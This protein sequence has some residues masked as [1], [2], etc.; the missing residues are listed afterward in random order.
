MDDAH[1]PP[2]GTY[3]WMLHYE[4][5]DF[6][7]YV[8]TRTEDGCLRGSYRAVRTN[9]GEPAPR[10]DLRIAEGAFHE[11]NAKTYDTLDEA[12]AEGED[13]R[14]GLLGQGWRAMTDR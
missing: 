4:W 6:A 3:V 2:R 8:L 12:L 9:D 11:V 13:L 10:G 14:Q 7:V 5:T 1:S